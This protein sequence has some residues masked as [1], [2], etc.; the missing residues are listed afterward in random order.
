MPDQKT[1]IRDREI[2]TSSLDG[3]WHAQWRVAGPEEDAFGGLPFTLLVQRRRACGIDR[4]GD[5]LTAV[6]GLQT[7]NSVEVVAWVDP[8]IIDVRPLLAPTDGVYV[9]QAR[10]YRGTLDVVRIGESLH[11][12]GTITHGDTAFTVRLEWVGP[13]P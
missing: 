12:A 10:C 13:L 6:F 8:A 9:R 2:R 1:N 5:L 3:I 11:L 4:Q 7:E